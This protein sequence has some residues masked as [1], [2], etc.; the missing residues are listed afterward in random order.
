MRG[1]GIPGL[2][3]PYGSGERNGKGRIKEFEMSR[4]SE[5]NPRGAEST[6][7]HGPGLRLRLYWKAMGFPKVRNTY[8]ITTNV[9]VRMRDSALLQADLYRP[10]GKP[11]AL[12]VLVRTPYSRG[13]ATTFAARFF[14]AQGYH[15]LVQS[16]RG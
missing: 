16:V 8:T 7:G 6:A 2:R 5:M 11:K 10:A 1:L 9:S 13:H 3:F 14:A 15:I 4:A 12:T